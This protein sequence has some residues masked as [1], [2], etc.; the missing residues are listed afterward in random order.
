MGACTWS[1]GFYFVPGITSTK[2]CASECSSKGYGKIVTV[3]KGRY[4][5]NCICTRGEAKCARTTSSSSHYNIY[6]CTCSRIHQPN[7]SWIQQSN[8]FCSR[9]LP[10]YRT[11]HAAE[12]ACIQGEERCSGIFD[13]NCDNKGD[14]Y[15]C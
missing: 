6:D 2:A 3:G 5:G 9:I 1:P 14:W 12:N 4:T 7:K 11:R 15:R 13:A 10:K 8:K